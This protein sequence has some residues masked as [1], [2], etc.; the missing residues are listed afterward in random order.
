ME[1]CALKH[2]EPDTKSR[3]LVSEFTDTTPTWRGNNWKDKAV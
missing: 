3:K 1:D 2:E